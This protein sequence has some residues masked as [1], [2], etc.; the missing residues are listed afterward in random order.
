MTPV[1]AMIT[2]DTMLFTLACNWLKDTVKE[3]FSVR[4]MMAEDMLVTLLCT[5]AAVCHASLMAVFIS[6]NALSN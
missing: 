1:L 5:P 4:L 2:G 6:Y 3:P